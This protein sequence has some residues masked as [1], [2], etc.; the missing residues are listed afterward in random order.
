ML[1]WFHKDSHSLQ[2]DHAIGN[3]RHNTSSN[4]NKSLIADFL[5][6]PVIVQAY[7]SK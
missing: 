2:I 6:N 5:T 3:L 4:W 7:I 1:W